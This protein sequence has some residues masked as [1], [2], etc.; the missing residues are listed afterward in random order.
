MRIVFGRQLAGKRSADDAGN[1]VAV[2]VRHDNEPGASERPFH[3][4]GRFGVVGLLDATAEE[5]VDLLVHAGI[6]H[7]VPVAVDDLE[8]RARL[9]AGLGSGAFD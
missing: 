7:H 2:L 1:V 6:D 8:H 4:S 5:L 3:L 9:H